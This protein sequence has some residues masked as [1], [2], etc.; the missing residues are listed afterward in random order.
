VFIIKNLAQRIEA[1]KR[2]W[3][4]L[5]KKC[6]ICCYG[7]DSRLLRTT[8]Y[9]SKPCEHFDKRTNLCRVYENRFKVCRYCAKV[10]LY[11][12]LFSRCLPDTCGYVE[13]YRRWRLVRGAEIKA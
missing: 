13:R 4:S 7:K 3:E 11:H 12:A 5:C 1:G 9:L 10:R 2:R 8:I 6:G